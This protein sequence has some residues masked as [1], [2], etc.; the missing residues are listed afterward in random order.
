MCQ[1][2]VESTCDKLRPIIFSETVEN[3]YVNDTLTIGTSLF[4]LY[5]SL[6]R[7]CQ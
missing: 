2:I 5:L 1:E 6:Q 7:L 4:E 3:D